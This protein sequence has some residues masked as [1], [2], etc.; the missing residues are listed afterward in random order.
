MTPRHF[1]PRRGE[2]GLAK[3]H[4]L[5][6]YSSFAAALML[7]MASVTALYWFAGVIGLPWYACVAVA[8]AIEVM[9][10]T[11]ASSATTARRENGKV[12][13]SAWAGFAF[14]IAIAAFANI[15]HVL[16]FIDVSNVPPWFPKGAF[17]AASCVFAAACPLGGTWGVHRFGWLRAHGADAQWTDTEE[18]VIVNGSGPV[19]RQAPRPARKPAQVSVQP[20]ARTE[21]TERAPEPVIAREQIP[22]AAQP[23]PER[24]SADAQPV[25]AQ[26]I[27]GDDAR[28][29]MRALFDQAVATNPHTKPDASKLHDAAGIGDSKSKATTRRW[30]GEWWD[31]F[32]ADR[33]ETERQFRELHAADPDQPDELEREALTVEREQRTAVA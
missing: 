16:T 18:G 14:F 7:M 17:I 26:A 28:D 4:R 11:Q 32:T 19:R 5:V 6:G 10:A 1:G 12:D 13:P 31:K 20:S 2:L 23:Q 8:L 21:Q 30:V 3:F 33:E 29:R 27:T 24:V 25:H 15:M 9:A 22:P